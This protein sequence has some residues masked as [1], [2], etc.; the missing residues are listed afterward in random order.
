M[1]AIQD[2]AAAGVE[3]ITVAVVGAG[4]GPLVAE[5]L[6]A[7]EVANIKVRFFSGFSKISIISLVETCLSRSLS[8][9]FQTIY[10]TRNFR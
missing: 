4:R 1:K 3:D 7:A 10:K 9:D 2:K 8:E 6:R 5:T